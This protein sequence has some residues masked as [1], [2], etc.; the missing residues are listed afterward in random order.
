MLTD[1][2][3]SPYAK[4]HP[5]D[6]NAVSW[7]DG[8]WS[9]VSKTC[10]EYTVPHIRETKKMIRKA[11]ENQQKGNGFSIVEVLSTCPSNW[12][13]TPKESIKRLQEECIPYYPLGVY[14]DV[15]I[16]QAN[17]DKLAMGGAAK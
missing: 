4:A 8:F 11:F 6:W 13:L 17:A 9:Q 7:T 12:G 1:T 16:A 2:T 3:H 5:L 14:K 15:E 10:A